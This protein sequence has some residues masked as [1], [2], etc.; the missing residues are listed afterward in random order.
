[1]KRVDQTITTHNQTAGEG[2]EGCMLLL[3]RNRLVNIQLV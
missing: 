3:S 2:G 1:M